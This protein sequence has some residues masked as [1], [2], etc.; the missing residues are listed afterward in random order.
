MIPNKQAP[1]VASNGERIVNDRFAQIPYYIIAVMGN[2]DFTLREYKVMMALLSV[3]EGFRV[4]SGFAVKMT[5]LTRNNYF[6]TRKQLEQKG[7]ITVK[8]DNIII[9][10]KW[11]RNMYSLIDALE[12]E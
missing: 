7:C 8:D 6:R 11:F 1:A 12:E 9:N 4:S 10:Y 5:G 2:F 3:A